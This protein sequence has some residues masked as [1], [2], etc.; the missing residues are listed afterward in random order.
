[1]RQNK[2]SEPSF[3]SR[4]K[5]ERYGG[6][7]EESRNNQNLCSADPGRRT[8]REKSGEFLKYVAESERKEERKER[9]KEGTSEIDFFSVT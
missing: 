2:V 3:S 1:M 4:E 7:R 8:L 9:R 5:K 6:V